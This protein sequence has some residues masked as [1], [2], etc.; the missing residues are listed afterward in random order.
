MNKG[1]NITKGIWVYEVEDF[2]KEIYTELDYI[3]LDEEYVFN[4][5]CD[6]RKLEELNNKLAT[7][8][9]NFIKTKNIKHGYDYIIFDGEDYFAVDI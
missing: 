7:G 5:K 3:D 8:R 4:K 9:V 2:E 1:G 6:K